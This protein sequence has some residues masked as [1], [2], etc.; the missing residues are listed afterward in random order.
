MPATY[1]NV[2]FDSFDMSEEGQEYEFMNMCS[3]NV[4][5]QFKVYWYSE[6]PRYWANEKAGL[7]V[8]L[9]NMA[10]DVVYQTVFFANKGKYIGDSGIGDSL[11]SYNEARAGNKTNDILLGSYYKHALGCD[12]YR[13]KIA[14][15]SPY[16]K[17][18]VI[19]RLYL[20]SSWK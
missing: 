3:E 8:S 14:N 13:I 12:K 11:K 17:G 19:A 4:G 20:D 15:L 2:R 16:E 6:E 18:L 9:M 7:E 10:G 5:F 1:H